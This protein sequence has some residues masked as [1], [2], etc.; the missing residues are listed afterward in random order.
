MQT[1]SGEIISCP[2]LYM[3]QHCK[4]FNADNARKALFDHIGSCIGTLDEYLLIVLLTHCAFSVYCLPQPFPVLC[5][6]ALA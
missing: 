3:L 4:S 1:H 5:S 6:R 2:H